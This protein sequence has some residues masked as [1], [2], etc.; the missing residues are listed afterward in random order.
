M[1]EGE[2]LLLLELSKT[3]SIEEIEVNEE[4]GYPLPVAVVCRKF[5]LKAA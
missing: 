3:W 2:D 5:L 4:A 1:R